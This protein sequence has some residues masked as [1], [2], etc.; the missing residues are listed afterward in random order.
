MGIMVAL[1]RFRASIVGLSTEMW[2]VCEDWKAEEVH[3]KYY[4][5]TTP[6]VSFRIRTLKSSEAECIGI[7]IYLLSSTYFNTWL[8]GV[9]IEMT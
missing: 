4:L 1:E 9:L 7:D 6:L 3:V 2:L 8:V 5:F